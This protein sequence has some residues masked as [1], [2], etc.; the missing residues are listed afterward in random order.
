MIA[1][2]KV[3]FWNVW[4]DLNHYPIIYLDKSPE[5]GAYELKSDFAKPG[6]SQSKRDK[7]HMY[8]FG[9][10][11]EK[12]KKVYIP[13]AKMYQDSHLLPGPGHYKNTH[14]T[15]GTEGK[16][17]LLKGKMAHFADPAVLR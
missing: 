9:V 14:Q 7:Q 12:Y 6:S 13:G 4:I 3:Q 11:H 16:S 10:P 8:S 17:F 2:S 15:M 5:P 1:W